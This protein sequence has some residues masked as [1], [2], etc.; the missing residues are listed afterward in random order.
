MAEAKAHKA[1]GKLSREA[2]V[3]AAED[4]FGEYGYNGSSLAMI[5][6]RVGI[7]QA[8]LLHHFGSKEQLLLTVLESHRAIDAETRARIEQADGLAALDAFATGFTAAFADRRWLQLF[9]VL[10]GESI[11]TDH[12]S[13]AYVVERYARLRES[14]RVA[15]SSGGDD[16]IRADADLDN[17]IS[18]LLAISNGLRTQLLIGEPVDVAGSFALGIELLRDHLRVRASV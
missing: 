6:T 3:A 12:P 10:L 7:T 5:S 11:L 14:L 16:A 9:A 2:I 4:V 1:R 15:L 8:G 17:V 18:L 13:R